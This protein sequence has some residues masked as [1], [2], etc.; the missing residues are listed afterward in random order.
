MLVQPGL[1]D[2]AC[3]FL[4]KRRIMHGG[5]FVDKKAG[6][7]NFVFALVLRFTWKLFR[8]QPIFWATHTEKLFQ[9]EQHRDN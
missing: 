4:V 3:V 8:F 7:N 2:Q 5:V 6:E 9:Q 1:A